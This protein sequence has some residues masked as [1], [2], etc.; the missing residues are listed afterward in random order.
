[1]N[2]PTIR[3]YKRLYEKYAKREQQRAI[4]SVAAGLVSAALGLWLLKRVRD[5][6]RAY[7]LR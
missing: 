5:D 3:E 7:P 2:N 6:I 4:S 1:V